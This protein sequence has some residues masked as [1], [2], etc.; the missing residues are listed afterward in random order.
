[1][2]FDVKKMIDGCYGGLRQK[3]HCMP[4]AVLIVWVLFVNIKPHSTYDEWGFGLFAI[5]GAKLFV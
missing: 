1:M 2:I 3:V 4:L 5:F